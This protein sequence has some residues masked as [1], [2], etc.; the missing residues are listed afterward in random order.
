MVEDELAR[1]VGVGAEDKSGEDCDLIA[2]KW[3]KYKPL[4][5]S[6]ELLESLLPW[7]GVEDRL[8]T[9]EGLGSVEKMVFGSKDQTVHVDFTTDTPSSGYLFVCPRLFRGQGLSME[10]SAFCEFAECLSKDLKLYGSMLGVKAGKRLE[11]VALHPLMVT[12]R[13]LPDF[14]RRAP[15]PALLF[16]VAESGI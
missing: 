4:M 8:I 6:G 7:R 10:V 16:R 9:P 11:V 1:D 13:G 14:S 3:V 2:E 15:H 5:E 12:S